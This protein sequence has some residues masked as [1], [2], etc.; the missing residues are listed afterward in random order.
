M[1]TGRYE[2][3]FL[4]PKFRDIKSMIL[5]YAKKNIT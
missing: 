5:L 3:S 2:R 4:K 1:V